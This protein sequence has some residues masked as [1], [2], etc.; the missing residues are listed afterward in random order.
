MEKKRVLIVEDDHNL[1]ALIELC[2]SETESY[3]VIKA[4][5]GEEAL[6]LIERNRFD[7]V[8]MDIQLRDTDG[9]EACS[10]LRTRHPRWA[11][12]VV[13]MTGQNGDDIRQA[14]EEAGG[15]GVLPKPFGVSKLLEVTAQYTQDR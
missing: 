1:R 5:S 4:A 8:L 9:F 6:E 7:L 3:E 10:H 11:T 2:L 15:D 12:S 14:V 13:F